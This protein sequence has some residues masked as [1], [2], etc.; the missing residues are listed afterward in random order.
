MRSIATSTLHDVK[1]KCI[2][3]HHSNTVKP[4]LT[5]DNQIKHLQ[6]ALSFMEKTVR[7]TLQFQEMYNHIQVG[8]KWFYVTKTTSSIYLVE[9]EDPPECQIQSKRY[10]PKVMFLC[11]V[12]RP[13][14]DSKRNQAFDGKVG[15]W[16]FTQLVAAMRLSRNCPAGSLETK[17]IV[18]T[19][20]VCRQFLCETS[21]MMLQWQQEKLMVG[22]LVF[23]VSHLILLTSIFWFWYPCCL[24]RWCLNSSEL[25]V[26]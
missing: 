9:D 15:L 17:P 16:P 3:L 4:A 6:F 8:E 24:P 12:A 2:T 10:I 19:I 5:D 11:T 20:E 22:I 25:G 18:V 23:N 7:G 14:H 21:Q 1:K 13:R 26:Q